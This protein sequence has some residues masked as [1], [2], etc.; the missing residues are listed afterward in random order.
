MAGTASEVAITITKKRKRPPLATDSIQG[1]CQ[2]RMQETRGFG[3]DILFEIL[4]L[5]PVKSL[6]RFRSVSRTWNSLIRDYPD[7]VKLH[8]ALSQSRPLATRLL[9]E[10]ALRSR[11]QR[12]DVESTYNSPTQLEGFPLQLVYEDSQIH[13]YNVTTRERKTL[14]FTLKSPKGWCP[15][16]Y[17]GFD[18]NTGK[19]KL[20]YH[21][22]KLH[23]KTKILTLGTNS[24]RVIDEKC[25]NNDHSEDCIYLN[26]VLYWNDGIPKTITYLNFIEK[27]GTLL[28]PHWTYSY[29]LN[30]M[31]TALL[32]KLVIHWYHIDYNGDV[33]CVEVNKVFMKFNTH[34]EE[35]KVVL[36]S[37]KKIRSGPQ[38]V[39]KDQ[40]VVD[41]Q[42][43]FV[44]QNPQQQLDVVTRDVLQSDRIVALAIGTH[45]NGVQ[46]GK[47]LIL[48]RPDDLG[49]GQRDRVS[50][51]VASPGERVG[52]EQASLVDASVTNQALVA[53]SWIQL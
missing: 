39:N 45:T 16:L 37:D 23:Y 13:L 15:V 28:L 30:K 47:E 43:N 4:V 50:M 42:A 48:A 34:L 38:V 6:L 41:H 33:V 31:Q 19:Y 53:F 44:Q 5:L 40:L 12:D 8:N 35:K 52:E 22:K 11:Y 1:S 49:D 20:L 14:P 26:G 32:G 9:F 3:Y 46:I 51:V 7:F 36:L 21:K 24:W 18:R 27:F 25:P 17:L 29:K 2:R 10:L